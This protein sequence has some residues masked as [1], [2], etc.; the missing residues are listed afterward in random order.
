MQLSQPLARSFPFSMWQDHGREYICEHFLGLLI[1]TAPIRGGTAAMQDFGRAGYIFGFLP[2]HIIRGILSWFR[3]SAVYQ[4]MGFTILSWWIW[5]PTTFLFA[6]DDGLMSFL[7]LWMGIRVGINGSRHFLGIAGYIGL[8]SACGSQE[9]RKPRWQ[10]TDT[11]MIQTI[12][13]ATSQSEN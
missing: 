6:I 3:L 4:G 8:G 7:W 13:K 9:A 5:Y 11:S 1:K 10:R 12:R 2:L